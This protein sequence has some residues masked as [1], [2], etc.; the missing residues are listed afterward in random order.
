MS[1]AVPAASAAGGALTAGDVVDVIAGGEDARYV[2]AAAPV[3]AVGGEG[4]LGLGG[5]QGLV[6]TL[7]VDDDEALRLAAAIAGGDV[8]LVRATGAPPVGEDP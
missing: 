2:V 6:V 8:Q 5:T 3:L 4:G 7:A 1:L